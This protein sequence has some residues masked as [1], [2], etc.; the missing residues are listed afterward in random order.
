[1][2]PA[3]R[4]Q[5][6]SQTMKFVIVIAASIAS[7]GLVLPTVTQ[8]QVRGISQQVAAAASQHTAELRA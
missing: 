1:M 8:G 4:T 2:T 3:R 5:K 6:G 7:A